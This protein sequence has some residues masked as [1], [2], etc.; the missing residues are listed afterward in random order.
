MN[1]KT[2]RVMFADGKTEDVQAHQASYDGAGNLCFLVITKG[3]M[4][5]KNPG[6]EQLEAIVTFKDFRSFR[7][8]SLSE[9]TRL[10][11]TGLIGQ[12]EAA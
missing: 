8:L 5:A 6:G 3:I 12:G 2:Y 10:N 11:V 1:M 4:T 9:K 7:D